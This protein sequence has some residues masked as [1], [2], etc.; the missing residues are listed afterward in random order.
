MFSRSLFAAG[1]R[2][3]VGVMGWQGGEVTG[4][5]GE[6]AEEAVTDGWCCDRVVSQ[7]WEASRSRCSL[8]PVGIWKGLF[9]RT[10]SNG[11][12]IWFCII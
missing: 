12:V 5:R 3:G 1:G 2:Q 7:R 6:E 9:R 11:V 8:R 10:Q 4:W